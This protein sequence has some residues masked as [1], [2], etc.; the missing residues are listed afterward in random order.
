MLS[1]NSKKSSPCAFI[2]VSPPV[3][4]AMRCSVWGTTTKLVLDSQANDARVGIIPDLIWLTITPSP[5]PILCGQKQAHPQTVEY[6]LGG[7]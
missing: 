1:A 6:D 7:C 2:E 4:L 5:M 3:H